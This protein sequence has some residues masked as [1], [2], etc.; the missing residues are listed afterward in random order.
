MG[1]SRSVVIAYCL[2]TNIS[3]G[4]WVASL[5]ERENYFWKSVIS[6]ILA[7]EKKEALM[8]GTLDACVVLKDF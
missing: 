5:P 4:P 2:P 8:I 3:S 1:K 7:T 6:V